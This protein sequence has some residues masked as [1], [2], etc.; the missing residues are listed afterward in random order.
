[1]QPLLGCSCALSSD[2][3]GACRHELRPEPQTLSECC[4][5]AQATTF[6]L[7]ESASGYA[8]FEAKGFDEVGAA[9]D[10]VQ[11]SIR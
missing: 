10:A 4:A 2:G 9:V 8:L 6:L 1:M 3:A 7:F 11:A 5:G